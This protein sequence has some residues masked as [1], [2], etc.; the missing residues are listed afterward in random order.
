MAQD[1]PYDLNKLRV[2]PAKVPRKPDKPKRWRR[3]FVHVPWEWRKRLRPAKRVCTYQLA[4]LLLYEHWRNGG[5]PIVLS[6]ALAADVELLPRSKWNALAELEQL[7]LV[8][9]KRCSHKSPRV[10]L[11]HLPRERP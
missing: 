1:D 8:R 2:D 11:C 3:H 5:H 4:L 7:E 10:T 9:V 6:N